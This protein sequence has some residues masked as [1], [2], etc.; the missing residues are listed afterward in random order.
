MAPQKG[1][2]PMLSSSPTL[3]KGALMGNPGVVRRIFSLCSV[4]CRIFLIFIV[5]KMVYVIKYLVLHNKH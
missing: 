3:E 5:Y 1:T 2:S 4:R